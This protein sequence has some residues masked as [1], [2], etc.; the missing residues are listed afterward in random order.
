[1][2]FETVKEFPEQKCKIIFERD[3]G[4]TLFQCKKRTVGIRR[5]GNVILD[6]RWRNMTFQQQ[7]CLKN[8]FLGGMYLHEVRED[9]KTGKILSK[10]LYQWGRVNCK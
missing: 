8:D 9:I 10:D 2:R 6:R 1:M 7:L 3:E 5:A 4:Y